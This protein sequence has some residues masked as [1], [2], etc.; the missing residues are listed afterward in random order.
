MSK[1]QALE[2]L[3]KLTAELRLTKKEHELVQQALA[4]LAK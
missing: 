3:S 2:L 4:V 1:E